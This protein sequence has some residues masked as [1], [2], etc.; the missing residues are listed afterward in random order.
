MTL[1][2]AV[3]AVSA[4]TGH[5]KL[6]RDSPVPDCALAE[7]WER[8]LFWNTH[9]FQTPLDPAE[10][11]GPA[12]MLCLRTRYIKHCK[13]LGVAENP[14]ELGQTPLSRS[15]CCSRR[16]VKR[17]WSNSVSKC[18]LPIIPEY[19]GFQDVKVCV[20][21]LSLQCMVTATYSSAG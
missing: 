2:G 8:E 20:P 18:A 16:M 9:C 10:M 7:N 12:S 21:K 13:P 19:P 3:C 5:C 6:S 1:L 15:C 11:E 14:P 4:G 17:E